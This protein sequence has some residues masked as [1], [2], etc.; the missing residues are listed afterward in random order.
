MNLEAA[1]SPRVA[2]LGIRYDGSS[3]YLRGA[4]EAPPAIRVA[5]WSDAGNPWTEPGVDLSTSA[6]D[7]EG[8]LEPAK[9][10]GSEQIRQRIEAASSRLSLRSHHGGEVGRPVGPGGD[11]Y[12]DASPT[13]AGPPV[14]GRGNRDEPGGLSVRQ[15]LGIIQSLGAPLVGADFVEFNPALDRTGVTAAVSVKLVKELAARMLVGD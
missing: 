12:H 3:S 13:R 9:G 4:A 10:E 5:L 2:L 1:A 11:P 8:D 14:R 15:A 6:L 7:D